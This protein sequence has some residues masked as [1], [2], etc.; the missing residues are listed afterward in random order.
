MIEDDI[1][2]VAEQPLAIDGP[3]RFDFDES[4]GHHVIAGQQRYRRSGLNEQ[5]PE[6]CARVEY[7]TS[8]LADGAERRL[9][10][11]VPPDGGD[12]QGAPVLGPGPEPALAHQAVTPGK[13]LPA[14]GPN[15][16]IGSSRSLTVILSHGKP[17]ADTGSSGP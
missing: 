1:A 4:G 2:Q 14:R 15:S 12:L 17:A 3:A 6:H 16:A 5:D 8:I 7:F 10:V 13:R 9:D 11:H